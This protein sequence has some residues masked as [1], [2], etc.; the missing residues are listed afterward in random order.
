MMAPVTFNIPGDA[1]AKGRPRMTRTGRAFT[2][3]RTVNAEAFVRM[4]AADA[5]A[6]QPPIDGPVRVVMRAVTVPA[7]SWS[8]KRQAV[9]LAGGERPTKRPDLDNQL[10]LITDAI[11]GIVYRD[12][13]QI[14]EVRASKQ[15]GPQAVTVVTVEAITP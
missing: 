9:A 14:C 1:V 2:P 3:K 12:D 11:N 4:A 6:G 13:C 7:A 5:M 8:K 15:Y 10:K